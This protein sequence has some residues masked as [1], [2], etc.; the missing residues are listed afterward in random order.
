MRPN[1][2]LWEKR[3]CNSQTT[4]L[5]WLV[6]DYCEYLLKLIRMV[7]GRTAGVWAN[8]HSLTVLELRRILPCFPKQ[9]PVTRIHLF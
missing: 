9:V 7:P 1:G 2:W 8:H 3:P 5:Q 4:H 6:N